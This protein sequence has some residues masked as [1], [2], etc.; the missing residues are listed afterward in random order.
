ME[1]EYQGGA[2]FWTVC[3]NWAG[4]P[5]D[6]HHRFLFD[7]CK[8]HKTPDMDG[9]N[10]GGALHDLGRFVGCPDILRCQCN[11]AFSHQPL[12]DPGYYGKLGF[13]VILISQSDRMLDRQIRALI[14]TEVRHRKLNNYGFGGMF[15]TLLTFGRTWFIA[16][17]YWYGGNR[18]K[19]TGGFYVQR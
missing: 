9:M 15:L 5:V 4:Q 2:G 10:R 6:K 14:E 3:H 19:L 18:L 1:G 8:C 7:A 17:D 16:I 11:R 13:N 12:R